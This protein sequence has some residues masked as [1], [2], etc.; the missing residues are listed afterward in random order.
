[1][2]ISEAP[3]PAIDRNRAAIQGL[4]VIIITK[5]EADIIEKC[6]SRLNFAQE[7]LLVDSGSTDGTVEKAR[8]L[9]AKVMSTDWPGFGPQK[10][11]AI[12]FATGPWI[13]SIDADEWLDETLVES[14]YSVLGQNATTPTS[15]PTVYKMK[16]VNF[17]RQ[18][19]IW[20][21]DWG[22][23]RPPRLF[24]KGAARF[25]DVLVH[26]GLQTSAPV[27]TLKGR[28]W[29]DSI[30]DF[31]EAR[32][33]YF[34]YAELASIEKKKKGQGGSIS[35]TLHGVF[36]FVRCYFLRLGLLDGSRGLQ[37]AWLGA[38][39]TFR[40]YYWAKHPR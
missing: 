38:V 15:G 28:L 34:R 30:A 19:A 17:Y 9:G 1:M 26:E 37:I 27:G 35:A 21:G 23:D 14:I 2:H 3:V 29:H 16:R 18:K 12:D 8:S 13:L 31:A 6:L 39:Y 22:G 36:A 4:S 33:K 24:C 7:L 5:N 20:F 10:N 32:N 40:K 11:R 25:T